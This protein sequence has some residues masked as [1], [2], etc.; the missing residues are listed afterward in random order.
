MY[1][2]YI[3]HK[4]NTDLYESAS[5]AIALKFDSLDALHYYIEATEK[6]IVDEVRYIIEKES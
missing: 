6:N 4:N 5:Y 3:V 2:L 1:E